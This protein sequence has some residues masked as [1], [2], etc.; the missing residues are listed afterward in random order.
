MA[1][2]SKTAPSLHATFTLG[3]GGLVV[4]L[5]L[6]NVS[7]TPLLVF[8]KLW[9]LDSA[10]KLVPDDQAIY[11]FVDEGALRLLLGVAPPPVNKTVAYRNVPYVTRVA[12]HATLEY[13]LTI[14]APVREH[15]PYFPAP[16]DQVFAATV[17]T[18]VELFVQYLPETP[19]IK[20]IASP[21]LPGAFSLATPG[22]WDGAPLL[23]SGSTPLSVPALRRT[24]TFARWSQR[25]AKP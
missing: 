3:T 4:H 22:V 9:N 17:V 13:D 1:S 8:D 2:P 24:D 23:R 12:A 5:E 15:N 20:V 10:S 7:D 19:D 14:A 16:N 18:A 6:S 21:V 11:R 25:S